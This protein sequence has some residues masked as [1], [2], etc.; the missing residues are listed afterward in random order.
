MNTWS[1]AA[2][3]KQ[4]N[5]VSNNTHAEDA[6][7][8]NV[9]TVSTYLRL[10]EEKNVDAWIELWADDAKYGLAEVTYLAPIRQPAPETVGGL[11]G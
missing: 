5:T 6:V 10:L 1:F 11:D 7:R 9:A 8:R 3:T 4:K 2:V